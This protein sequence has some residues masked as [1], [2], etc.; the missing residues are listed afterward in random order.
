MHDWLGIGLI[1]LGLGL[2]AAG[3]RKYRTRMRT[4]LSAGAIRP[5]FAAMGEMIR[6][7][8]LFAVGFVSLK[9]TVFYFLFDGRRFLSQLDFAGVLFVLAAYAGYLVL[10][11]KKPLVAPATSGERVDG[12][13]RS[14][15]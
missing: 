2:L 6:P 15:A 4:P 12:E 13:A 1:A 10:A 3:F 7:M 11:T 9:M 5:E 8:V 14:P